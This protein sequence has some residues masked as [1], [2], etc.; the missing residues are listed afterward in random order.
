[1]WR[2]RLVLLLSSSALA[3]AGCQKHQN[4]SAWRIVQEA[5]IR[6]AAFRFLFRDQTLDEA[7]LKG[8]CY[9]LAVGDYPRLRDPSTE[10]MR[11]FVGRQPPVKALSSCNGPEVECVRD[12]DTRVQGIL[13]HVGKIT[14]HNDNEVVVHCGYYLANLGGKLGSAVFTRTGGVW[15]F[16][17][18]LEFI[19]G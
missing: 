5:D 1:M 10:M 9:Y 8:G 13:A 12:L 15:R 2:M 4:D 7:G 3:V 14:W 6:E 18:S 11:R 17:K 19:V 16:T